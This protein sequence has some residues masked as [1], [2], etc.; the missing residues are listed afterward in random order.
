MVVSWYASL[1]LCVI[2]LHMFS[3]SFVYPQLFKWLLASKRAKWK[4]LGPYALE[5]TPHFKSILLAN[6]SH[7]V[8]PDSM[9]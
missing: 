7:K 2:S 5:C 8:I 6:A 4:L 3:D 9:G 1:V